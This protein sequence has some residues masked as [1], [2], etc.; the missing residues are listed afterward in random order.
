MSLDDAFADRQPNS[1]PRVFGAGM[2]PLKDGE[3]VLGMFRINS[4]AVVLN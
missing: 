3:D 4:D 2:Q 1:C